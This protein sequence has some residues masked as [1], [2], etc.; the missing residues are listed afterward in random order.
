MERVIN[1]SGERCDKTSRPVR[2]CK[3]IVCGCLCPH[4]VSDLATRP[5]NP[6]VLSAVHFTLTTCHDPL[7]TC[8]CEPPKSLLVH[9]FVS[10]EM[11]FRTTLLVSTAFLCANAYPHSPIER[12]ADSNN[13][14][15][16]NTAVTKYVEFICGHALVLLAVALIVLFFARS[17]LMSL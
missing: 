5:V 2:Q 11:A 9:P 4:A 8:T 10:P 1:G 3:C 17:L 15:G 16:G 12:R 13:G 7:K 6:C 14:S